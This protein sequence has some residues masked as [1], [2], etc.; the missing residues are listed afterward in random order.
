MGRR[1]VDALG[2][3]GAEG[4]VVGGVGGNAGGGEVVVHDAA[5]EG[6]FGEAGGDDALDDEGGMVEVGGEVEGRVGAWGVA[7]GDGDV[8]GGVERAC[9]VGA[10]GEP[11]ADPGDDALLA[12][13]GGGDLRE[14]KEPAEVGGAVGF[15]EGG[16]GGW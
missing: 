11:A 16:H 14:F 5:A 12:A 1:A 9:E 4:A 13:G 6:E 10:I 2:E 3:A 8:A 7:E 15:G